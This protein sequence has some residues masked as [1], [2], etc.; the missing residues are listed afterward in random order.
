ME[1]YLG[2]SWV[3]IVHA[4]SYRDRFEYFGEKLHSKIKSV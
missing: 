1:I 3:T 4:T 2:K